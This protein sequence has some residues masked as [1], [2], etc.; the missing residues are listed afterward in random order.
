MDRLART[1]SC[2]DLARASDALTQHSD[3]SRLSF[4]PIRSPR[5]R[6]DAVFRRAP[7][8]SAALLAFSLVT[9]FQPAALASAG[10]PSA[11]SSEASGA[12]VTTDAIQALIRAGRYAEAERQA[13]ALLGECE[14]IYGAESMQTA[15]VLDLLAEAMRNAGSTNAPDAEAICER[16]VRI[17]EKLA[18][19]NS[20]AYATSLHNLGA[21]YM[22]RGDYDRARTLLEQ[23]IEIRRKTLGEN[24]PEVARSMLFLANLETTLGRDPAALPLVERA[25]EIQRSSLG[26]DDLERARGISML[27]ALKYNLGDYTSPGPLWEQ[28]LAVRRRTL[29][30]DHPLVAETL[31]NLAALE[32]ETGD[33]DRALDDYQQALNIR[34]ARLGPT[35]RYVVSTLVNIATT[36]I[37]VGD[38]EGARKRYLEALTIQERNGATKI[39]IAWTLTVMGR[40][41]VSE[42]RYAEAKPY[43]VRARALQDGELDP[44]S[45]QRCQ[46]MVPLAAVAADE[47][48]RTEATRLFEQALR[49]QQSVYGEA[50]PDA[51]TTMGSFS[52]FL[53]AAGDSVRSFDLALKASLARANLIRA[54]TQGLSERQ[55]LA[56][57]AAGRRPVDVL[58]GLACRHSDPSWT[59]RAYDALIRTRTLVLDEIAERHR[60]TL[61]QSADSTVASAMRDLDGARRRYANLLVRGVGASDPQRYR[62]AI[63]RARDEVESA[64]RTLSTRSG[65][66]PIH[67]RS[68]GWSEVASALPRGWGLVSY[69]LFGSGRERRYMAFV[70]RPGRDLVALPIGSATRVDLLVRRWAGSLARGGG[71]GGTR[72][73][74]HEEAATRMAGA[75]LRR[76]VWDPLRDAVGG[77]D[78][79]LLVPDG[80]LHL[81]NL[82][83]LPTETGSY[84]IETGPAV[85]YLSAERD[86]VRGPAHARGR[87]LLALGG[88]SFDLPEAVSGALTDTAPGHTGAAAATRGR[89][90]GSPWRGPQPDCADFRN[91][92]FLALPETERE[93]NE[94]SAA[95]G[96]SSEVIRLVGPRAGE[97]AFKAL[98]PGCRIL[99]LATHGFFLDATSCGSERPGIRG[100]GGIASTHPT[101]VRE[102]Q[103][104]TS[105]LL[106]SGLALAGANLR[107][108]ARPDQEDGV[109]MA[110]E[111]VSLDLSSAEWVVL[112]A[113]DTGLGRVQAGE[114]VLGLRRAFETAGAS[115]V[116]MSL[117][118][119]EDRSA[120]EWMRDL[121]DERFRKGRSTWESVHG[122]TLDV[123]RGRRARGLST[124]PHYWAGFVAAGDWN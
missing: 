47:G 36:L 123:L 44:D 6:F 23:T 79:I 75:E 28:V 105:P 83:A 81:V 122:A 60:A 34:R 48:R 20:A 2:P 116:I 84:F 87:G 59:R 119:V 94:V 21:F 57:A 102:R 103:A 101:V 1:S 74:A 56:Y 70:A 82:S 16:A 42:G 90:R 107:L 69:A 106:L 80:A 68:V 67:A 10:V 11:V 4:G 77:L 51:I 114:G 35:N 113:C 110:Q 33:Y 55:A 37:N 115:T 19:K 18:G 38:L 43:L 117:W 30:A 53:A 26:P 15:D 109:L 63:G 50:C 54:T 22:A 40:M 14:Q 93:V 104:D 41:L 61:L 99:H 5:S 112:S 65:R 32:S 72:F 124:H 118:E 3:P 121:Y 12:S 88:A 46:V 31:H 97:T 13:R 58:L 8:R 92:R 52:E 7:V 27:A 89:T 71:S 95:W 96:D 73:G 86:L 9:S 29:G 39:D 108:Q 111:V 25:V 85:H 62:D 98:A 91:A 49:I 17:K 78:R 24:A 66:A 76:A 100:I 64:E 45:W 120:R